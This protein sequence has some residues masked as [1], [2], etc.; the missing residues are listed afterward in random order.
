[1]ELDDED[2]ELLGFGAERLYEAS[3]SQI[4]KRQEQV[5][6]AWNRYAK[7]QKGK[8]AIERR[9]EKRR[10]S[11]YFADF[12]KANAEKIKARVKAYHEKHRND[13]EY[14]A[15]R[16]ARDRARYLKRKGEKR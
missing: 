7:T 12:Y 1:M 4:V 5:R 8:A 6:A 2:Y 3:A 10:A 14:K 16:A 11:T 9:D 15:K 13:A